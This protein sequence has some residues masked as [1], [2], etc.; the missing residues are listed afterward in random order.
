LAC[1]A[2]LVALS[3]SAGKE[4]FAR[5]EAHYPRG[6][7]RLL[8][9]R[10][11]DVLP[12]SGGRLA[13]LVED[14]AVSPAPFGRG[15][16]A[17]RLVA[18]VDELLAALESMP[19]VD[20]T[21]AWP[22][23]VYPFSPRGNPG[24]F[25]ARARAMRRG[26]VATAYLD[27]GR[28]GG[29]G[30]AG[31]SEP[32]AG[33]GGDDARRGD[34][35]G[36]TSASCIQTEAALQAYRALSIEAPLRKAAWRWRCRLTARGSPET[37]P[38]A[39][40]MLL[41]QKDLIDPSLQ[42]AFSRSGLGHL[43]AVSGLHV[44]FVLAL[45]MPLIAQVRGRKRAV[46]FL[47]DRV[48]AWAGFA[49]LAA[50][51]LAYVALAGGPASAV[52]AGLMALTAV[53]A[54]ELGRPV[55]PWQALGVAGTLLLVYQPHFALDLGFQMS[56]LAVAG[57]L[58][59]VG[60]GRA[61]VREE[62]LTLNS[63]RSGS[64]LW[65][66]AVSAGAVGLTVTLGAQAATAPL[67]AAAFSE[68]SWIS[69]AVNLVAVPAGGAGV[70]LLAAGV[71]IGEVW[72]PLGDWLLDAGHRVT[73]L[74]VALAR[75]VSPWGAIEVAMPSAA[76]VAGWYLAGFGVA[77]VFRAV[78]CPAA[79]SLVRLGKRALIAGVVLL[80]VGI[81]WPGVKGLL[82][83]TEVWV[84]DVGQGD[85]ILVRSGWGRA[86]MIDGGGVPGAA[87]TGGFDVGERRVVPALKRLGVRRLEAVINT[88]PH[89]DHVHGLAAVVARRDVRAVFAPEGEPAGAAYRAFAEAAKA[90]GI[91]IQHLWPGATLWLEPGVSLTVLT[92]GTMAEWEGEAGLGM[93][94]VNDR[95]I[96]LL[97]RHG[98]FR[99]LF[100]GDI[101]ER[102]Q[103]RLLR[104]ERVRVE[105]AIAGLDLLVVPHHGDKVTAATGFLEVTRPRVAVISVGPNRYGHP[106]TALIEKLLEKRAQV[107]RTDEH[108]AIRIEFWPWGV[109]T[110]SVR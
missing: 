35:A 7:K 37:A 110:S 57:I 51:V 36:G 29:R 41:G 85:A 73:G 69:P 46:S 88:H 44:G 63:R 18:E 21:I 82:G 96:V 3:A 25:D 48:R 107:W 98:R 5:R 78:R 17:V 31:A 22:V 99:A 4:E 39:V 12:H 83:V 10:V 68:L 89:E 92:A 34:A 28:A 81:S 80:A 100:A 104:Q 49:L 55:D 50:L 14:G 53:L 59:A 77:C 8:Y 56:F 91:E 13:L 70:I 43:L 52:R 33:A 32:T 16:Y 108:G 15:P 20:G 71:L 66:R 86:V 64:G 60:S 1:L 30:S 65:G 45:V 58:G 54:R 79:A 72:A 84:L 6:E 106:S 101:E 102:G 67:L 103:I 94:S 24:E 42:Q 26:Y 47:V 2:S 11:I 76:A 95:S 90:K 105:P 27:V 9:G 40:A 38:I 23:R 62:T 75:A 87:A 97:L 74:V 109:R 61:K 93:P 19:P